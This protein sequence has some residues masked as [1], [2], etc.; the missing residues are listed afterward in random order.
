[1]FGIILSI[2][3][4]II[5]DTLLGGNKIMK[6]GLISKTKVS[7]KSKTNNKYMFDLIEHNKNHIKQNNKYNISK[8]EK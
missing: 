5:F 1:M 3:L 8:I 7:N 4:G 6:M 2:I